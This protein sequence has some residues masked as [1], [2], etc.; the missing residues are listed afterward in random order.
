MTPRKMTGPILVILMA[1][2][3]STAQAAT[4]DQVRT[5]KDCTATLN[6]SPPAGAVEPQ[7][8]LAECEGV[9][10]PPRVGDAELVT[11]PP[12]VG[13]MPVIRPGELPAQN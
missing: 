13:T 7:A 1:A 5:D 10:E 6:E 2:F 4:E 8:G 11:E 3:A 12:E 9:I